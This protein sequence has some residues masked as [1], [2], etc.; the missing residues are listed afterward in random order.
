MDVDYGKT[1]AL[2]VRL[3]HVEHAPGLVIGDVER[4]AFPGSG[5]VR[6]LSLA[7]ARGARGS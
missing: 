1:G 5:R 7:R 6:G 3:L 2:D 4:L